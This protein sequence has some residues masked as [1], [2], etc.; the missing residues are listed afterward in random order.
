MKAAMIRKID[1][2]PEVDLRARELVGVVLA[3][4]APENE[5]VVASLRVCAASV[6]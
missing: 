5:H 1:H 6:A 2:P 3:P 4:A